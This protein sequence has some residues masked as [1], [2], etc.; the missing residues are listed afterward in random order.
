MLY[1]SRSRAAPTVW[2]QQTDKGEEKTTGN[3]Q[4]KSETVQIKLSGRQQLSVTTQSSPT[5][6][7]LCSRPP[8][9]ARSESL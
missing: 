8:R 2:L 7:S 6:L 5:A 3:Q 9:S 1:I 4:N